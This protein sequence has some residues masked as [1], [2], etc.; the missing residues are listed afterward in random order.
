MRQLLLAILLCSST[1]LAGPRVEVEARGATLDQAKK[2]A[3]RTAIEQT[4]GNLIV[5]DVEAQG[6]KLTKDFIGSYSAGYIEDYEVL[7]HYQ[8]QENQWN[9]RMNIKVATSKI[10]ERMRSTARSNANIQGA[11]IYDRIASEIEMRESGDALL[12]TVLASYPQNA[13]VIN[14]GETV[15]DIE[16]LRDPYVD[17]PYKLSMSR[18]WI[19]AFNEAVKNV[20]VDSKSCNTLTMSV[21]QSVEA[22]VRT[23]QATKDLA[24]RVCGKDPDVR[25]FYK[26]AGDFLP[27]GYSYY[28]ADQV[29]FDTINNEFLPPAGQQHIGLQ[30]DLIDAGGSIIDSRCAKINNQVFI[31]YSDPVGTYNI[32]D[33]RRLSRPNVMGQNSVDGTLRVHLKTVEQIENLA[34][35][36]LTVQKTCN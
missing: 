18:F 9:V 4:V 28:L 17:I 15:F 29:T 7:E 3:F 8:D 26:A 13:Y 1:A 23:G 5:S 10:A 22:G 34:R 16:R 35:I 2:N 36:K 12:S 11:K 30:V 20:A 27:K 14:S 33:K 32:R 24:Q 21:T 19:E 25:V 6:D 31:N